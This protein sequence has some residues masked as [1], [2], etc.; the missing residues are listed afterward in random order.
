MPSSNVS[1]FF[2]LLFL[3]G[4]PSE[5]ACGKLNKSIHLIVLQVS[6]R[7]DQTNVHFALI[8]LPQLCALHVWTTSK[9]V[10]L[11][12]R[13]LL[14]TFLSWLFFHSTSHK[15]VSSNPRKLPKLRFASNISKTSARVSAEVPNTEKLMK[16]RG[17]RRSAFIVSRCLEPLMK[18]DARLFEMISPM[19]QYGPNYAVLDL[20]LYVWF[21]AF[22]RHLL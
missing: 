19:K 22:S 4:Y 7:F 11:C 16:G 18:P 2:Y 20:T 14:E 1:V 17:R 15:K 10:F 12:S 6:G 5:V 9:F 8:V 21:V 13:V 3:Q